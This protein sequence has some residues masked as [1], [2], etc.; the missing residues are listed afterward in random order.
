MR[1]NAVLTNKIYGHRPW[2]QNWL[3]YTAM[4]YFFKKFRS[5][6]TANKG[7]LGQRAVKLSSVKV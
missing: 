5:S 1:S 6:N 3:V 2:R 7:F 4:I